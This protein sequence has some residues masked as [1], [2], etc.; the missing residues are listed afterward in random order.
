MSS[1]SPVVQAFIRA[2]P[3]SLAQA[4]RAARVIAGGISHDIR[5]LAPFPLS[6]ASASGAN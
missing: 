4:A 6:L 3:L 2:R 5:S 1:A